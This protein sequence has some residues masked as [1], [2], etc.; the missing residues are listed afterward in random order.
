MDRDDEVGVTYQIS[1]PFVKESPLQSVHY[2]RLWRYN[3]PVVF[4]LEG[5]SRSILS[6]S[7]PTVLQGDAA[8]PSSP[9]GVSPFDENV[10]CDSGPS[11]GAGDSPEQAMALPRFSQVGRS[12]R[13]PAHFRDFVM[14]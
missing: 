2:D 12:S 4:P 10:N 9:V 1:G 8:V 7:P 3:L 13:P 14:G 6:P 5:P 11:L